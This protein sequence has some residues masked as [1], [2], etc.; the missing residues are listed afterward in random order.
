[1]KARKALGEI[2][3]EKGLV[4]QDVIDS[5][6]QK[7]KT[8]GSRLGEL[9][10][11]GGILTEEQVVEAVS[12]QGHKRVNLLELDYID[13]DVLNKFEVEYMRNQLIIPFAIEND[14]LRVVMNDQSNF[15]AVDYVLNTIGLRKID[16]CIGTRNEIEQFL[17]LR[18]GTSFIS[19]NQEEEEEVVDDVTIFDSDSPLVTYVNEILE[20]AVR[21]RASDI[22][23][24]PQISKDS[25]VRYRIDGR[26]VTKSTFQR[27][28]HSK[29]ISRIKVM[30]DL[31]ITNHLSSQ[32]GD[33]V[34]KLPIGNINMRV[35]IV[36]TVIGEKAVLRLMGLSTAL[37]DLDEIGLTEE[38]K[39]I[40]KRNLDKRNGMILLT[41]PTGAGKTTTLY[42]S[43]NYLNDES[44]NISSIEDSVEIRLVGVN[45]LKIS[46]NF[47]FDEALTAMLRQDPD[48]MM[49]GE[50]RDKVSANTAIRAAITGHLVLSTIHTGDVYG[51][52]G[53]LLNLDI[54]GYMVSDALT[55]VVAQR[56]VTRLCPKCKAVD[57]EGTALLREL[58]NDDSLVSYKEVGC[59]SCGNTGIKGRVAIFEMLEIDGELKKL[60][61]KSQ[62]DEVYKKPLTSDPMYMDGIKKVI[63]GT[64]SYGAL[65]KI[66]GVSHKILK[67]EMTRHAS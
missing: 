67:E 13:E 38:N 36:P 59:N 60:I 51:V 29:V 18:F 66:L 42:S 9:L 22:H 11:R 37:Y 52:V 43:M 8:D 64:T 17:N 15:M 33:L 57:E 1:M 28:W 3:V 4:T 62:L 35:S 7:Q 40:L 27:S 41:A 12:Q 6:V 5:Y 45:Q 63:A 10:V 48:I 39:E 2:L 47:T 19:N 32:D 61:S 21:N 25:R 23:I 44:I 54:E 20:N 26:L 50:M 24:E 30:S 56:L 65:L 58:M 46:K 34:F 31:E 16:T 53:R 55:L 49:V 14:R